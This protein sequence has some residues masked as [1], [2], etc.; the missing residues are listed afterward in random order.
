MGEKL[1]HTLVNPNYMRHHRISARQLLHENPMGI[2]CPEEE[3]MLPLY[4]SGNFFVL[5]PCH[6]HR[7]S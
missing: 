3:V 7:N 2:T 4:M 6:Q 5:T 1:Y